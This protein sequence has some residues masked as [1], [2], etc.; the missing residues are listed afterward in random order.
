[1]SIECVVLDRYRE[2][3]EERELRSQGIYTALGIAL[4]SIPLAVAELAILPYDTNTEKETYLVVEVSV[5][6]NICIL[7]MNLLA[8]KAIADELPLTMRV[9]VV[10]VWI[11]DAVLIALVLF[12]A[13]AFLSFSI[14]TIFSFI[15]RVLM[16]FVY[17]VIAIQCIQFWN[18]YDNH[19]LMGKIGKNRDVSLAV[20]IGIL[21]MAVLIAFIYIITV[22]EENAWRVM[23]W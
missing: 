4:L 14:T 15:L 17:L 3:P 12:D 16:I 13:Y 18:M 7:A 20:T 10:E 2:Y 8:L 22:A 9:Y 19:R 11:I 1:M 21:G 6:V 23:F 5:I